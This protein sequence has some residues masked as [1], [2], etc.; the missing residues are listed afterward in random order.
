MP[1]AMAAGRAEAALA[2]RLGSLA[3]RVTRPERILA[4]GATRVMP[5]GAWAPGPGPA[6]RAA[7]AVPLIPQ[8]GLRG[9]RPDPVKWGP[10]ITEPARSGCVEST[11]VPST[12][13]V[14]P[15]PLLDSCA[16]VTCSA[17]SHHSS[18]RIWSATAGAAV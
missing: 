14:T 4:L 3:S 7:T 2:F 15:E 1:L 13:T 16:V 18:L 9:V 17:L 12:A 6:I 10:V 11:P 8:K 5:S